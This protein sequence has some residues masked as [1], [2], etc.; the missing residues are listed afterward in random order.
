MCTTDMNDTGGKLDT[1]TASVIDTG[2]KFVSKKIL[3]NQIED[4]F[5]LPPVSTTPVQWCT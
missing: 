3:K 1:S 4:F 2:D 5:D